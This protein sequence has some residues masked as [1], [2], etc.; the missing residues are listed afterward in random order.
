[1]SRAA[2]AEVKQPQTL[3][4]G[5][6]EL[7]INN[8]KPLTKNKNNPRVKIVIGKVKKIIIGLT[9]AL[10]KASNKAAKIAVKKLSTRNIF[11][12]LPT[13]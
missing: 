12:T 11:V 8:E 4:F 1:M 10:I 2:R 13:I 7:T 5:T 9:T 3:N 6:N